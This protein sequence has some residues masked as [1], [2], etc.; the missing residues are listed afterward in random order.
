MV[1]E[2]YALALKVLIALAAVGYKV[3][4]LG[5]IIRQVPVGNPHYPH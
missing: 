5:G 3:F 1:V 4:S 2:Q